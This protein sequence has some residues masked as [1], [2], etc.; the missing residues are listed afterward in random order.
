MG[1]YGVCS[2]KTRE[3]VTPLERA[4]GGTVSEAKPKRTVG[5]RVRRVRL[6]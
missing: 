4:A 1:A 2:L 3:A 5:L 6:C